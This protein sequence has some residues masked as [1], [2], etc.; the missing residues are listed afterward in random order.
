MEKCLGWTEKEQ[1]SLQIMN[2]SKISSVAEHL[3]DNHKYFENFE[4]DRFKIIK[5][6]GNILIL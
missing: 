4:L 6:C 1:K 5:S 2:A 3:V